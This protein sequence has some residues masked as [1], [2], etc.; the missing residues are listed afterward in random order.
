MN[1]KRHTNI[2]LLVIVAIAAFTIWVDLPG[3]RQVLGTTVAIRQGLDLQGGVQVLLEADM[4]H[5]EAVDLDDMR[6]ARTILEN[7]VNGLGVTEPVVQLQGERRII[8]ELPGIQNS[9][10]AIRTI[11]AT[12]L[13]EFIEGDYMLLPGDLVRT[14]QTSGNETVYDGVDPSLIYGPY[15][16]AMTG[17]VIRDAFVD[18]DEMG[19]Y[20]V[21]FQVK[22]EW[23]KRF[24]EYTGEHIGDY[25]TIVLDKRVVSNAVIRDAISDAGVISGGS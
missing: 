12:A 16:T 23:T 21:A 9:D 18:R 11:Q 15:Q 8:V 20:K 13:L 24:R 17:E 7:R 5:E 4:P 22:S 14:S 25:F 10:Q 6:V 1:R 3:S 2:W 19:N